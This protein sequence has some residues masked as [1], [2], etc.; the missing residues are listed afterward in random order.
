M[1]DVAYRGFLCLIA[2]SLLLVVRWLG[3]FYGWD[4]Y[5]T[6][7]L[8]ASLICPFTSAAIARSSKGQSDA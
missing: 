8:S 6:G 4:D 3:R 1:A 2:L 5:F 7:F